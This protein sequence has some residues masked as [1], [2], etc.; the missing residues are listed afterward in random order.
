[1]LLPFT[2]I[3]LAFEEGYPLPTRVK[4]TVLAGVLWCMYTINFKQAHARISI[5]FQSSQFLFQPRIFYQLGVIQQ[6]FKRI[7]FDLLAQ[8]SECARTREDTIDIYTIS[9]ALPQ[10][11]GSEKIAREKLKMP[12]RDKDSP[13]LS[14]VLPAP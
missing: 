2:Q 10:K 6:W 4:S 14:T 13:T 8:L 9:L 3:R 1:V 11:R 5:S 7:T 12:L